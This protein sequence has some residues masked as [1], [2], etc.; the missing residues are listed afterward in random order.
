MP[1]W[2]QVGRSPITNVEPDMSSTVRART[3]CLPS[4][5]PSGPSTKL[6]N[7]RITKVTAR[8]AKVASAPSEVLPALKNVWPRIAGMKPKTPKSYHSMQFPIAD[9]ATALR[10]AFGSGTVSACG[11]CVF[12][13]AM[14]PPRP[15]S[16]VRPVSAKVQ[17]FATA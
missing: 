6:P 14:R 16:C 10:T 9:P 3:F 1:I 8:S 17:P 13:A 4:L 12:S 11:V 15:D 5:S 2:S 7:G